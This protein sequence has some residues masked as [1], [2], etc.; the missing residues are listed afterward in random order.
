MPLS[1]AIL[2]LI[3]QWL[4]QSAM[5][6]LLIQRVLLRLIHNQADQLPVETVG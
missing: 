2:P 5:F 6:L 3:R 1:D 4:S